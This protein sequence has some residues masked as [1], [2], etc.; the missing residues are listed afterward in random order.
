VVRGLVVLHATEKAILV[1]EADTLEA[2][3]ASG[4]SA[5]PFKKWLP[6]S[7]IRRATPA[8]ETLDNG[9]AV[10]L[11]VPR[12]LAEDKEFMFDE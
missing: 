8:L 5:K 11:V 4:D 3:A 6:R 12:W 2:C 1:I 9:D 7:Q 10:E